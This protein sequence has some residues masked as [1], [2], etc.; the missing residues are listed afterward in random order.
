M[1]KL[2]LAILVTQVIT[3][4]DAIENPDAL[5]SSEDTISTT[6]VSEISLPAI[7]RTVSSVDPA[8][9]QLTT[10]VN[11]TATELRREEDD[12]W[13][14]IV[15]V[16]RN[17]NSS[18]YLE[19]GVNYGTAGY[20]KLASRQQNVFVSG[21]EGSV[22]FSGNYNTEYDLDIDFRSNLVEL[23]QNR[24]PVKHFDAYIQE[25]GTSVPGGIEYPFSSDCGRQI[26]IAVATEL[27]DSEE[28]GAP[29]QGLEA[30]WCARLKPSL[31]DADG[32]LVDIY[33]L[34]FTV[35]VIDDIVLDN[36][37]GENNTT[38]FDDSIEIFIDGD[39]NK[40]GAYDGRNDFQF[41][42]AP[43]GDGV[44]TRR[45]GPAVSDNVSASV[46]YFSGGYKLIAIFPLDDVG[47]CGGLPFGLNIEVND[48][49]DG[50]NRDAK[51][52]WI[53]TENID[54]SWRNTRL[55]GTSQIDP[56]NPC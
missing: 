24:S 36:G 34:E 54:N 16:P 12:I 40:G 7:L 49:D 6:S 45:R 38:H 43:F 8:T 14:G 4:C 51:Y 48:D 41:Q 28:P 10:R 23:N 29:G 47:I 21:E 19:W 3:G 13:R 22:T 17:Q 2:G 35:N 46:S 9:F 27:P 15:E 33:N 20:L 53:G 26:P 56:V 18:V 39:D 31:T 25:S 37:T 42:F 52:A 32:N 55:F 11:G 1:R 44:F 5:T 30:W 50:G